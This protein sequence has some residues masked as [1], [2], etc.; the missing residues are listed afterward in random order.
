QQET[1]QAGLKENKSAEDVLDRGYGYTN[2]IN[3]LF[4]AMAR[5]A[6]FRPAIV[7]L[8]DRRRAALDRGVL[9]PTQLNSMVV[10]VPMAD[11]DL[12]LD[13]ATRF[14]PYGMV[15][16]YENGVKGLSVSNIVNDFVT[17]PGEHSDA[18]VTK[19]SVELRVA[20]DGHV[21]GTFQISFAGQEAL[22]RRLELYDEDD[23]GRRKALE[24]E[25]R[26]W[27]PEG[28]TVEVR[29]IF[30]CDS[31]EEDLRVEGE[32][33]VP[34]FATIAGRRLLVPTAVFRNFRENP[35][36]PLKRTYEIYF[37]H[38]YRVEDKVRLQAP[39]DFRVESLPNQHDDQVDCCHY[40]TNFKSHDRTVDFE[41]SFA[42]DGFIFP[43]SVYPGLRLFFGKMIANDGE[44]VVLQQAN[45][46]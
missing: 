8:A 5:A 43:Q 4:V 46:K 3:Y 24:E 41:R 1:K 45:Q 40:L 44:Q 21:D 29:H 38:S 28:A 6:G 25:I 20:G 14:C 2:E 18:A 10:M 27:L 16:W 30:A 15:P 31:S 34:Q 42:V 17:I 9:D 33:S 39:D 19:R 36:Q 7:M 12:Y 35:F 23:N 26:G 22:T 37:R 11:H 32:F 13:P